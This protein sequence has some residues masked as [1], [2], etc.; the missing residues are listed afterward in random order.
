[1]MS[2]ISINH[3]AGKIPLEIRSTAVKTQHKSVILRTLHV[4]ETLFWITLLALFDLH[5]DGASS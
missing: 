4:N 5:A 3:T 1:M 2:F